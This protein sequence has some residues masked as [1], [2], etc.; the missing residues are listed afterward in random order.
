MSTTTTKPEPLA[1][2]MLLI[3]LRDFAGVEGWDLDRRAKLEALL[4]RYVKVYSADV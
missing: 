2:Q 1:K 4:D 3:E